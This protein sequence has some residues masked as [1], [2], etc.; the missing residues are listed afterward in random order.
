MQEPRL[1]LVGKIVR[2][3]GIKGAV[4]VFP[5]GES[6]AAQDVGAKLFVAAESGQE[7]ETFTVVS[8][9]PQGRYWVMRFQEVMSVDEAQDIVG[10]E[11]FL[12]EDRLPATLEGEYYHYQLIGL[13]VVTKEGEMVGTLQGIIE[14]GGNDVYSIYRNG[15]EVLVPAIE[16]VICEVDLGRSRMVIDP[17]EGLMDDL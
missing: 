9:H 12:P 1:I 14:T 13:E 10:K 16:E 8:A 6:L 5:Y 11:V 2:T 7:A 4:K 3:H 15:K 17:P